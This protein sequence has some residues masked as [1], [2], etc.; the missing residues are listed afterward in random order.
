MGGLKSYLFSSITDLGKS[1]VKV[2]IVNVCIDMFF[3]S[4]N[5]LGMESPAQGQREI[6]PERVK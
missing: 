3:P 5:Y 1:Q 4:D 6:V 2:N